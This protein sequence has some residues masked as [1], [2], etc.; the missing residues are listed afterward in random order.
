MAL[1]LTFS[2]GQRVTGAQLQSIVDQVNAIVTVGSWN[3]ISSFSNSWS[4][5]FKY[6]L[7][8]VPVNK[9]ELFITMNPGTETAGTTVCTLPVGYRPANSLDIGL[10][11]DKS[12]SGGQT[13]HFFIQSNGVVAAYGIG[14][15][16]DYVH[17]DGYIPLD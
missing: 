9:L 13:P 11:S 6:R 17:F 15:A 3:T 7:V 14:S 12:L 4:G 2:A 1:S 5:T 8:T 16:S 10:I